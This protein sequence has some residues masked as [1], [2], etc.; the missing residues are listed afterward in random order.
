MKLKSAAIVIL[1]LASSLAAGA[2]D[3]QFRRQP[4][5]LP[6]RAEN[7]IVADVNGD[8]LNDLIC[9]IDER[10]RVY[11]QHSDGFDFD[12]GFAELV[13]EARAI[14]WDISHGY[15]DN[16]HAEIITL[17]DGQQVLAWPMVGSD[18]IEPRVVH[19][20]LN[21]FLPRGLNR[22]YF[23]RDINH[24]RLDDLVIPAAGQLQ[25]YIRG[26]GGYQAPLAVQSDMR[27]RTTLATER[28]QGRTGQAISIPLMELRD[29]NNDGHD[30][31]ISRTDEKLDVFI[32]APQ[33]ARYFPGQPSYS[34]DIAAIE[35]RLGEFDIDNLDFSNLTG[36]LALTHEE[37]LEDINGDGIAD[38][39]LREGGKVSLFSGTAAGMDFSQPQQVLRSGGNVLSTFVHDENEDGLKDLWLW[40]VEPISV[41]DVFLWLA[42][43][44]SIAVEAFIYPNEGE[45][46]AR[47]PSRRISVDLRFPSVI[48]MATSFREISQE[49]DNTQ[50]DDIVPTALGQLDGIGDRQDLLV[51]VNNQLQIFLDSIEPQQQERPFLG[52]LGYSR[53][54]DNYEIN[55][56]ELIDNISVRGN[57]RLDAVTGRS[58]QQVID[59]QQTVVNGDVVTALLN[60]DT[61]DDVF[62]FTSHSSEAINGVLLLS[63]DDAG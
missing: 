38:L 58:A 32:A 36:V 39:L 62:I 5:Q 33:G 28:L 63:S 14:G 2:D 20:G 50:S 24:D 9:E 45:R 7:L 35:E 4:F 61:L 56:R 23:S 16:G 10:L 59:L 29:V 52:A 3:W 60:N 6:A 48:R 34:L 53:Q 22:L 8:G 13:F 43:S 44:G 12:N 51:L 26:D 31:L 41:G 17:L 30:D 46:F 57:P 25:I 18:F 55:L 47:R 54:R 42:L 11:T 1:L 27:I 37:I 21:G 15:N 40:R 49:A 19:D